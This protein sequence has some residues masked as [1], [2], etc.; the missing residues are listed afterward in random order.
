MTDRPALTD[1]VHPLVLKVENIIATDER[2]GGRTQRELAALIVGCVLAESSGHQEA[3][4]GDF[5]AEAH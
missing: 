1:R 2:E 5:N 3:V 4:A